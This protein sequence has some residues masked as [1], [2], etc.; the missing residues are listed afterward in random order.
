MTDILSVRYLSSC[1]PSFRHTQFPDDP[2]RDGV[3]M[4]FVSCPTRHKLQRVKIFVFALVFTIRSLQAIF[5]RNC[6]FDVV[7]TPQSQSSE[8]N[9]PVPKRP[10]ILMVRVCTSPKEK[11]SKFGIVRVCTP[12]YK[13]FLFSN[14]N[15]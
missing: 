9:L 13:E 12:N 10:L 5:Y 2:S 3:P 11:C 14:F 4:L 1:S 6:L 15:G 7:L 8:C